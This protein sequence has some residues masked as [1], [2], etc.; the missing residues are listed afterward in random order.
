M[1]KIK[2]PKG[3]F[4]DRCREEGTAD[5]GTKLVCL[6]SE[7]HTKSDD[8]RRAMHYDSDEE[9]YFGAPGKIEITIEV[10]GQEMVT[11]TESLPKGWANMTEDQRRSHLAWR[12]EDVKDMVEVNAEYNPKS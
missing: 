6:K 7:G 9:L 11:I 8:P 5:D 3:L 2:D 1:A 4:S 10:P 12:E